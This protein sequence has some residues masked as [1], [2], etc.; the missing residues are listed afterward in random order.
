L[1]VRMGNAMVLTPRGRALLPPVKHFVD[2]AAGILIDDEARGPATFDREVRL[3]CSEYVQITLASVFPKI[4]TLA[5]RLRLS[6]LPMVSAD[7]AHEALAVGNIDL[8]VGIMTDSLGLLRIQRLYSEPFVCLTRVAPG[9]APRGLSF[10]EFCTLPHL[11]VS[12]TGRRILGARIDSEAQR[13]GGT[14]R[15]VS[16]VSSFMAAA[17]IVADT[18]MICLVPQQVG[19]RVQRPPAVVA[20]DLLFPSPTLDVVMYWHNVTQQDPVCTWLREQLLLE[21]GDATADT[22]RVKRRRS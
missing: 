13:Q 20:V 5:P 6:F 7:V 8:M 15:V 1:L 16:T 19:L 9:A 2:S 11:D 21:F 22:R 3:S 14:R 4:Q 17:Q 10:D 12:P 18:G